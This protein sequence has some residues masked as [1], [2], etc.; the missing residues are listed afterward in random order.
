MTSKQGRSGARTTP[1][2]VRC[3][4]YTRKS[5]QEGLDMEFNSLEA[6]REAGEVFV[7]SQASEGWICLPER[8]DDGG[9]TGANTDRPALRRLLADIEAGKVDTV[10]V[11][12]VDRL[13]RS[14]LDFARLME[15]FEKHRV[16]FVSVT[17]QFNTATSMGRL[18]LN[19][20]LSFAQFEREIIAERTRDK[21]AATRRKGKWAGGHPL[22]GFDV[23]PRALRLVVNEA[24]AERVRA[25]FDLYLL[26]ESLLPVVEELE[27]R[28]WVNKKWVTR[29]GHARGGRLFTRTSLHRLLS[30]VAYL[31]KVRYRDE[32][33]PG[34]H[35]GIVDPAVFQQA[36]DLLQRNGRSGGAPVRNKFGAL[37]KGLV[38]C[39]PCGCSMT[40]AHTTRK[41]S[42][43]YFYYVCSGAQKRGWKT[44][45]S[46]S[47]PAA[48][49]EQF[50]LD[51]IRCIG[52]DPVLLQEILSQAREEGLASVAEL[53]AEQRV[54][55]KDL[56]RW[57]GEV[58]QLSGQLRPGDDSGPVI[59]R[60]ADVQERIGR[61]QE[62]RGVV[63]AEHQAAQQQMIE[64]GETA[65]ALAQFDPIWQSLSP[66]EQTR[67]IELLVRRVDYDGR[68]STV[69]VAFHATGIKTLADEL[70][71][72]R[73]GRSP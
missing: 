40:P 12:K 65:R 23:D 34:E 1:P 15:T 36:Q 47:I 20:L 62:R 33:H 22:L 19:V 25:I 52:R 31:G 4:I 2:Q 64:E 11:Y 26:H 72:E 42:K 71:Q 39:T 24:E 10:I 49:L 61:A 56:A 69:T 54:L 17:Q 41:G 21:I 63:R 50:V 68:R 48:Q 51:Q 66:R 70:A 5:V 32:V 29:K 30:N 45:P 6:Q 46:K 16:A 8:F 3:V 43:R 60:L 7:K 38:H 13:S 55:E 37:L 14:L 9:H 18:V 57:H 58:R 27:R 67:V 53:E 28:G 35:A 59:S 73:E 44:C